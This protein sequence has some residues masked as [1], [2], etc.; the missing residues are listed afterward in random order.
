[1]DLSHFSVFSITK[2]ELEQRRVGVDESSTIN[3]TDI[4]EGT[5]RRY[6]VKK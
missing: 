6:N 5:R 3:L 4:I 1:M 2:Y